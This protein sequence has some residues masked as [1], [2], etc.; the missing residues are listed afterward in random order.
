[1]SERRFTLIF[2]VALL[3]G[4]LATYGVYRFVTA[5]KLAS[6][7]VGRIETGPV[8]VLAGHVSAGSAL[9][10]T[11]LTQSYFPVEAIPAG[12]FSETASAVGRIA[13]NALYPDEP[14]LE[15]KLAPLGFQ[16]GIEVKITPGHRAMPIR[17]TDVVGVTGLIRP[18]SR[19]DVLAIMGARTAGL[20][21][22][23]GKIFLQNMRVL[24]VGT[25]TERGDPKQPLTSTALTL[26]VTPEQAEIMAVAMNDGALSLVLRN[27]T[28]PD[29]A[30]TQGASTQ[31]LLAG[32]PILKLSPKPK[33]KARSQPVRR[34][35]PRPRPVTAAP[36]PTS[37]TVQ[38]YRGSRLSEEKVERDTLST[39]R[40]RE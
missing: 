1:M 18:E 40:R 11:D 9:N 20:S 8:V 13:R 7:Q 2:L 19:V 14:L 36:Q 23:V 31:M 22:T 25:Q 15:S 30:K 35:T 33:P 39:G 27:F 10:E 17:V 26:E 24:S 34:P 21:Q 37:R 16:P 5:Q 29:S 32:I 12:S 6:A 3:I 4:S 38:V 28:D